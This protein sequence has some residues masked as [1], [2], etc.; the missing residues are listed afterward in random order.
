MRR[1]R[2]RGSAVRIAVAAVVVLLLAPAAAILAL[3]WVDPPV[4]A[5]MLRVHAAADVPGPSIH[6]VWRDLEGIAPD[7]ALAVVAAEDQT[8]P[9]H[10]GFV[11]SAIGDALQE[12]ADGGRLRG[13]SSISQQV[14]KNLFLWPGQSWLRKG[15]EAY[16]TVWL[17]LLWPKRR[18]LEVYLNI[19]QFG[20]RTFGAEAAARRYFGVAAAGLA[21]EQ[22]ALLAAALPAPERYRVVP[23]SPYMRERQA[24]ILGQMRQLGPG[25]LR[26]L[27]VAAK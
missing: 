12:G 24:W 6:Y 11:W 17:E 7:L 22:A 25:Y 27:L 15:I 19:A 23:P 9:R 16:L 13:A 4:T 3:R 20:D 26:G 1:R 5:F 18:I 14:V 21:P 2:G 10:H 8:F